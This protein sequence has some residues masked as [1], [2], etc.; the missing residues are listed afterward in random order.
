MGE[1]ATRLADEAVLTSDNPRSEDPGSI[2]DAVRAGA[3]PT[4]VLHIEPD[5]RAAIARALTRAAA[6]DVVVIAGKGHETTQQFADHAVPFDDREVA[7]QELERLGW[8]GR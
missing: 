3:H 6:G 4:G 7:R 2:I 8:S 1:V 5:R